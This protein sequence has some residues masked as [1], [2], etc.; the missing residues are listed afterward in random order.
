MQ[1]ESALV[2]MQTN[3]TNV[4][5]PESAATSSSTTTHVCECA[6][7]KNGSSTNQ[8]DQFSKKNS[9]KGRCVRQTIIQWTGIRAPYIAHTARIIC[10]GF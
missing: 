3:N 7:H 10:R 1:L 8:F 9:L 5:F 2:A 4:F 6:A